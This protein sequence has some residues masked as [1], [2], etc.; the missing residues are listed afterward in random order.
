MKDLQSTYVLMIYFFKFL[1]YL[2]K[3]INNFFANLMCLGQF[4]NF[5]S[6]SVTFLYVSFTH[7][8]LIKQDCFCLVPENVNS[9]EG[10]TG[11]GK[12][13]ILLK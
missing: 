9:I 12:K 4:L 6:N 8:Q 13:F 11:N 3:I 7:R 2:K 5:F 10:A 1:P